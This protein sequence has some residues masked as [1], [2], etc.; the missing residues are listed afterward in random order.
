MDN[1]LVPSV[2]K[3]LEATL[4]NSHASFIQMS[5]KDFLSIQQRFIRTGSMVY[6][7]EEL[8]LTCGESQVS[9]HSL[10]YIRTKNKPTQYYSASK[11]FRVPPSEFLGDKEER[12]ILQWFITRKGEFLKE[13]YALSNLQ[14][15]HLFDAELKEVEA[16]S[17]VFKQQ[18][19]HDE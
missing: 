6:K 1:E 19:D 8:E 12:Q 9:Y 7:S 3:G 2:D 10:C 4:K 13:Q 5:R 18:Q 15:K 16:C 14:R 11:T 17:D